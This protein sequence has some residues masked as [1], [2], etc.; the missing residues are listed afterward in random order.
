MVVSIKNYV[1]HRVK[2]RSEFIAPKTHQTQMPH[3]WVALRLLWNDGCRLEILEKNPIVCDLQH[4]W[5]QKFYQDIHSHT[6]SKI[7]PH[8]I[9]LWKTKIMSRLYEKKTF[10]TKTYESSQDNFT[11]THNFIPFYCYLLLSVSAFIHFL[12]CIILT[13][14][15]NDEML[16]CSVFPLFFCI[17]FHHTTNNDKTQSNNE[18]NDDNWRKGFNQLYWIVN[19]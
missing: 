11:Y 19:T 8:I 13:L 3:T 6:H 10:V 2:Y 18:K 5:V 15:I 9:S 4:R 17:F 12:F 1:R 16:L 14:L 7:P